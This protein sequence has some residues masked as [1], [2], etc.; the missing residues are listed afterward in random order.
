MSTLP[1]EALAELASAKHRLEHPSLAAR[2]SNYVG[3]PIES[4]IQKLP[5]AAQGAIEQVTHRSLEKVSDWA[6]LTM[7]E[8]AD[9]EMRLGFHKILAA[10]SGAA[11]GAVGL[12]GLAIEL[13]V[14]TGII[15]RSILDI[16]RA[17]GED[18]RDV[19][20][21]LEGLSVFALGGSS[22]DDDGAESGY[23]AARMLLAKAVSEAAVHVAAKGI[24][25]KGGPAIVRLISQIAARFSIPVSSKAAAQAVPIIGAIGGAT[26]NTLFID[27]FQDMA[28]GH[29][30]VRRLERAHGEEAVRQAWNQ[31]GTGE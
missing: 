25:Q 11:G 13:P 16:A 19:Q 12:A 23:F 29:F 27:H 1:P 21:R 5:D 30:T 8:Q 6:V 28:R 3:S 26:L 31:L 2:L 20:V 9:S 7:D 4:A 10:A 24:G 18:I 17:N 14:S 15:M 22:P